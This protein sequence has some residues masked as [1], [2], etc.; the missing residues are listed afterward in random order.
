MCWLR[1]VCLL[2]DGTLGCVACW[3][4]LVATLGSL[5]LSV[6]CCR[7]F[8]VILL[9]ISLNFVIACICL[10][11]SLSYGVHPQ[12]ASRCLV[13]MIV[14]L[15]SCEGRIQLCVQFFLLWCL[16]RRHGGTGSGRVLVPSTMHQHL[17]RSMTHIVLLFHI[18]LFCSLVVLVVSR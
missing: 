16:G 3:F 13:V 1:R 18:Q 2:V 14:V 10:S 9:K 6:L 17:L 7:V 15:H 8:L 4:S 12:H 11:P 5:G